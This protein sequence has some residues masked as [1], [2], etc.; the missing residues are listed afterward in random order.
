MDDPLLAG[1]IEY[2]LRKSGY[3][4]QKAEDGQQAS[5]LLTRE[6]FD[7]LLLDVMIPKLDG[8]RLL[9][10]L[11]KPGRRA[12]RAILVLTARAGEDDMLRAFELGA[13]DYVVKPF[14][15]NVLVKRIEIALGRGV[16]AAATPAT[17]ARPS[18]APAQMIT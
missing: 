15:L 6:S 2:K 12:P 4:V 16:E 14:S 5:D 10:E 7:A 11:R 1:L 3:T 17:A 13:V 8:F 9:H 18:R